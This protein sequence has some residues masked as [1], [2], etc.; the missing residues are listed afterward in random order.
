MWVQT[1][2]Y[3]L[4]SLLLADRLDRGLPHRVHRPYGRRVVIETSQGC[5]AGRLRPSP[6]CGGWTG[7]ARN[8][9]RRPKTTGILQN[10]G[11]ALRQGRDQPRGI[12][13]ATDRPA[14]K[15]LRRERQR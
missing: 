15:G 11:R 9:T 14:V 6:G 13:A 1:G 7:R 3:Q 10:A 4:T 12:H 8:G 2:D 5:D